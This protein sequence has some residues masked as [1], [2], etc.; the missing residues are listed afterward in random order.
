MIFYERTK[1]LY[2]CGVFPI[3]KYFD[4]IFLAHPARELY[5]AVFLS[6][7]MKF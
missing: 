1:E 3:L 4:I 2:C 6:K 7:K 5:F